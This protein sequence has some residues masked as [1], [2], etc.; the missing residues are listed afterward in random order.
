[1][2]KLSTKLSFDICLEFRRFKETAKTIS[3]VLRVAKEI[4]RTHLL[5][6]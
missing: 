1:M 5:K 6:S 3:K 4:T 2:I